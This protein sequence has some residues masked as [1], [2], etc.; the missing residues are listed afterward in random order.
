MAKKTVFM[1]MMITILCCSILLAGCGKDDEGIING[2]KTDDNRSE[3]LMQEPSADDVGSDNRLNALVVNNESDDELEN[4]TGSEEGDAD[5]SEAPLG[6]LIVSF[7]DVGIGDG[8]FV[9][10]P[11][12]KTL[13]VDSGDDSVGGM[14][15]QYLRSRGVTDRIDAIVATHPDKENI[16][17]VDSVLYNI[18]AAPE[19]Y[20]NGEERSSQYYISF[21]EF[22]KMRGIL[23]AITED[24][25]VTIDPIMGIQLI[26]PYTEGYMNNSNDNSIVVKMTYGDV[27]ILLM[28]DCGFECE[29]KIMGRDLR[30]DVIKIAHGGANDSTSQELLDNAKPK[31]AVI[32]TGKGEDGEFASADVIE[33]LRS[34]GIEVLRTDLNGTIIVES[35][36]KT[37][38]ARP[39]E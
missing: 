38:T 13:L 8:I 12:N 5:I 20:F 14:L 17:A 26:V 1:C 25:G 3:E 23:N 9:Q 21:I 30:A 39:M 27:S 18:A 29:Q 34:N 4:G 10:T 28:G 36:G 24:T 15:M 6:N 31:L 37:F 32:S 2:S 7:L 11:N 22:S 33:R 35:D 16:G 19:I